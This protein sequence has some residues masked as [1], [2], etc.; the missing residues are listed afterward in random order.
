M[1]FSVRQG[2]R[3]FPAASAALALVPLAGILLTGCVEPG[4]R[5][6][7]VVSPPSAIAP[8]PSDAGSGVPSAEAGM[9]LVQ[10]SFE[11]RTVQALVGQAENTAASRPPLDHGAVALPARAFETP[12]VAQANLIQSPS[13]PSLTMADRVVAL[14]TQTMLAGLACGRVWADPSAFQR[15]ADFTVRN[16]SLLR[17]SQSE[18]AGRLGGVEAF[19]RM[20]TRIS[21]GESRRLIDL[22]DAVYCA[23]MR[24]PFYVVVALDEP[25][26]AGMAMDHETVIASLQ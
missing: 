14:Q 24:K 19:D 1:G 17:R 2:R 13:M 21:N 15:Y 26:L 18:V 7:L 10:P 12:S 11:M 9:K 23:E 16:S 3:A 25:R 20:H 8:L 22:G 5:E 6:P 4:V